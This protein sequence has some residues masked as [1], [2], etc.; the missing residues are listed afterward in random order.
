MEGQPTHGLPH[1]LDLHLL[2]ALL[3]AILLSAAAMHH[4]IQMYPSS[5]T[6]VSLFYYP[7]QTQQSEMAMYVFFVLVQFYRHYQG[8]R[9]NKKESYS[10]LVY[11]FLLSFPII[12]GFVYFLRL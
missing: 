2:R 5:I 10:L 4:P 6:A 12:L 3:P 1:A 8:D 11:Y 7:T 9:A